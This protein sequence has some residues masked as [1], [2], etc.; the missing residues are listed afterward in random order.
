MGEEPGFCGFCDVFRVLWYFSKVF[1]GFYGVLVFFSW[2]SFMVF[3]FYDLW[4]L[5]DFLIPLTLLK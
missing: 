2:F 4:Y 3:V 1:E 5:G